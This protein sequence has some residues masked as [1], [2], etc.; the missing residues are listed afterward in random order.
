MSNSNQNIIQW[1]QNHGKAKLG[2]ESE[3]IHGRVH[4]V[5]GERRRTCGASGPAST[6]LPASTSSGRCKT[7]APS[8]TPAGREEL[9][10]LPW[11]HSQISSD[12]TR[13]RRRPMPACLDAWSEW[14]SQLQCLW[15]VLLAPRSCRPGSSFAWREQASRASRSRTTPLSSAN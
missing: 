3:E 9:S 7:L 6:W 12:W 10:L 4:V 8:R 13:L 15:A 11:S 14:V 5:R 2:F 1:P